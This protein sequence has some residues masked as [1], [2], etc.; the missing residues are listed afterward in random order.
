MDKPKYKRIEG[1]THKWNKPA[2]TPK[3]PA[4]IWCAAIPPGLNGSK[5]SAPQD[6]V[7]A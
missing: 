4:A 2:R 7:T 5:P 3:I 1:R 6:G